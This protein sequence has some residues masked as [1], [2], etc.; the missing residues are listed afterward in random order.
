MMRYEYH[1]DIYHDMIDRSFHSLTA[2]LALISIIGGKNVRK[3]LRVGLTFE[4]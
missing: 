4:D 2:K 3:A 1:Y